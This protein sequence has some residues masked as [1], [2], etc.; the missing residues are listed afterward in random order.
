M[1]QITKDLNLLKDED[2]ITILLYCLYRFKDDSDYSTLAELAFTVDKDSMYNLCATF[3]GTTL[4]I[5]TLDEYK[6]VAK[7]MLVFD[8]MNS[9]G[10]N[11]ADSCDK[12]GLDCTNSEVIRLYEIMKEVINLYEEQN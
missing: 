8:F 6:T 11:F 5:P 3:G 2:L 9:D 1:K 7:V 4:K 12:A 10:L